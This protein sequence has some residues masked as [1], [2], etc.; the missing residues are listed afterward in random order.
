MYPEVTSSDTPAS[1][2]H[3]DVAES[4]NG[5]EV[6]LHDMALRLH[7]QDTVAIAK[8][9]LQ[10]GTV[11]VLAGDAPGSPLRVAIRQFI[12]SGHKVALIERTP[13]QELYRYGQIIGFAT[14]PIEPGEHVHTHNLGMQDLSRDYA[15]GVE[16]H[17]V[18]Y[19]PAGERQ[20]FRGYRR[21]NGQV[22]TRNYVAV[23]GTANCSAHACREI[24][25]HFTP[26][27]LAPYPNVD[28]VIALTHTIGCSMRPDGLDLEILR[29]TLAGMAR[30]PNVGA[31]LL[32]GLGCE[33]N[34]V[35]GLVENCGLRDG[36][37]TSDPPPSL[38]IQ[39]VGG[40]RKTVA[41]GSRPA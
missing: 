36:G 28:G 35:A 33:T 41:A 4:R 31:H 1:T 32:I 9:D 37:P 29:R 17:P 3:H 25:H 27:R 16:A 11:L 30:H 19:V 24:A 22:G 10:P 39:D 15:F 26:E 13:G 20:T 34:Q 14:Q 40:L 6:M 21:A 12:P 5:G 8:T 38:T 18:D 7:P 2:E 23:I